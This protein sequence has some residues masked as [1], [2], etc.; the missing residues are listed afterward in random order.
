MHFTSVHLQAV[1]NTTFKLLPLA[2]LQLSMFFFNYRRTAALG[3][4]H[5]SVFEPLSRTNAGRFPPHAAATYGETYI[6]GDRG[7]LDTQNNTSRQK[8]KKEEIK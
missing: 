4:Q 5:S 6:K 2:Q 3:S 7:A 8:K 1:F